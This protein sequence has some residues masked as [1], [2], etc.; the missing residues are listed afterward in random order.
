MGKLNEA[1]ELVDSLKAKAADQSQVLAQKQQEADQ[2]LQEITTTMQNASEQKTEMEE[3][4]KQV[5]CV[6]VCVC[7]C[8]YMC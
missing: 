1:K 4:K 5:V 2:S 8:V 6:C 3:L 7:M